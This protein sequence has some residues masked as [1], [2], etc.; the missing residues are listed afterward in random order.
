MTRSYIFGEREVVL[1]QKPLNHR[2]EEPNDVGPILCTTVSANLK[3]Q[4]FILNH[5]KL[6][7]IFAGFEAIVDIL[8]GH[9]EIQDINRA[10]L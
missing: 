1:Q 8:R 10:L 7:R 9:L 5:L 2:A 6:N 4:G 3:G